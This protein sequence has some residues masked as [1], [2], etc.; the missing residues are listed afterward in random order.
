M[1]TSN[2]INTPTKYIMDNT[3][4]FS[5]KFLL[6]LN[7]TNKP[8]PQPVSKPDNNVP[9][10]I[11]LDKYNSVIITL[12]AQ[13]GISPIKLATKYVTIF[14]LINKLLSLSS[15]VLNITIFITKLAIKINNPIFKVCL[16]L[17]TNKF[18]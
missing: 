13:F 10:V 9:I 17:E 15:P 16:I 7:N 4:I 3:I 14:L 1:S 11:S 8:R 2:P 12:L 5:F 18:S 6:V